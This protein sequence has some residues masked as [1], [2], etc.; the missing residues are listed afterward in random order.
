MSPERTVLTLILLVTTVF[1]LR[2]PYTSQT[3]SFAGFSRRLQDNTTNS[4]T[5]DNTTDTNTSNPILGAQVSEQICSGYVYV[6]STVE[7]QE[8]SEDVASQIR[9][10]RS[11]GTLQDLI[12]KDYVQSDLLTGYVKKFVPF[13]AAL[14]VPLAISLV[15]FILCLMNWCCMCC[16]CCSSMRCGICSRPST[17]ANIN[18]YAFISFI[19]CLFVLGASVAALIVYSDFSGKFEGAMCQSTYMLAE[20]HDGLPD[21]KWF[22]IERLKNLLKDLGDQVWSTRTLFREMEQEFTT[23]DDKTTEISTDLHALEDGFNNRTLPRAYFIEEDTYVPQ[24]T[25]TLGNHMT[26]AY[27]ELDMFQTNLTDAKAYFDSAVSEFNAKRVDVVKVLDSG[28]G[29]ARDMEKDITDSLDWLSSNG[30]TLMRYGK[31]FTKGLKIALAIA[32]GLSGFAL[33]SVIGNFWSKYKHFNKCMHMAWILL[34]IFM[35]IGWIAATILFPLTIACV[36]TCQVVDGVLNNETFANQTLNAFFGVKKSVLKDSI[37][38]C[39]HG[40]GE[41]IDNFG[42]KDNIN[43]IN[44]INDEIDSNAAL[45]DQGQIPT[46]IDIQQLRDHLNSI[47]ANSQLD[48]AKTITDLNLLTQLSNS[49]LDGTRCAAVN[50]AWV[51][52]DANC[53]ALDLNSILQS[54]QPDNYDVGQAL[55]IPLARWMEPSGRDIETRYT[56]QLYQNCAPTTYT[57]NQTIYQRADLLDQMVNRFVENRIELGQIIQDISTEIDAINV[58]AD[59]LLND[60]R[61]ALKAPFTTVKNF[62]EEIKTEVFDQNTGLIYNTQCTFVETRVRSLHDELCVSLIPTIYDTAIAM[63]VGA[64]MA[65]IVTLSLFFFMR[66]LMAKQE[67]FDGDNRKTHPQ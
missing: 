17:K 37:V 24:F 35:V 36:E 18:M 44:T 26:E 66:K 43:L 1:L 32:I 3:T 20:L 46:S 49:N 53:T 13:L 21:Q 51:L 28:Y 56:N 10:F 29:Q 60:S 34:G 2:K 12:S 63:I 54:D 22:G 23:L 14:G 15:L 31:N 8:N 52:S 40:S 38:L 57:P 67:S 55:C 9:T 4:V 5:S 30:N 27:D 59:S 11:E 19:F 50:D 64:V 48:D 58:K 6:P 65:S 16:P 7:E 45:I 47:D 39:L 25:Q 62:V 61:N 33:L 41:I 42:I